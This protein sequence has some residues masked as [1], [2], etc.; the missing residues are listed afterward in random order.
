MVRN[1]IY[2]VMWLSMVRRI[3]A[4]KCRRMAHTR[5]KRKS[6]IGGTCCTHRSCPIL[7][8]VQH[9]YIY[10]IKWQH[11]VERVA[12]AE[13]TARIAAHLIKMLPT[14]APQH[15]WV[16]VRER[17]LWTMQWSDSKEFDDESAV[18][19]AQNKMRASTSNRAMYSTCF[20]LSL[21]FHWRK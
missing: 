15:V 7:C 5:R 8:I 13:L 6:S 17:A 10:A 2:V 12:I 4:T 20:Q 21:L 19:M 11:H 1:R 14:G 9:I 3:I 18:R 16:C